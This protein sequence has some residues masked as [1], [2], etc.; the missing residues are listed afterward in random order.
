MKILCPLKQKIT[1]VISDR[2]QWIQFPA[3]ALLRS[4]EIIEKW[5]FGEKIKPVMKLH[6][7]GQIVSLFIVIWC[8]VSWGIYCYHRLKLCCYHNRRLAESPH[9]MPA[10][11]HCL[12]SFISSPVHCR[13]P[14][15]HFVS[16]SPGTDPSLK[17]PA[18]FPNYILSPFTCLVLT[19]H[20]EVRGFQWVKKGNIELP[21]LSVF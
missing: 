15:P 8:T 16:Y 9:L 10:L 14:P 13:T 12:C 1:P 6:W 11:Q 19:L 7:W 18:N 5:K 2:Q 21:S 3:V 17:T 4:L 20:L